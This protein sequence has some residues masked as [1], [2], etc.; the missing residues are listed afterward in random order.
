MS[1]E[2]RVIFATRVSHDRVELRS[3]LDWKIVTTLILLPA[4]SSLVLDFYLPVTRFAHGESLE[5]NA[6]NLL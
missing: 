4:E 3:R 5:G 1:R 6:F 2:N